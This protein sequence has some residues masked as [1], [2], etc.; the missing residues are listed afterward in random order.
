[1]LGSTHININAP[2]SLFLQVKY[3]SRHAHSAD[4]AACSSRCPAV[5]RWGSTSATFVLSS[6]LADMLTYSSISSSCGACL[7]LASTPLHVV[8]GQPEQRGP[9]AYW[10]RA[11]LQ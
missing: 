5:L 7:A 6:I 11:L 8:D 10:L 9:R 2:S 1:M 3:G 4:A